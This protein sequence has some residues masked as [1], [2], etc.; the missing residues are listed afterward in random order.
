MADFR[1]FAPIAGLI[2]FFTGTRG[3]RRGTWFGSRDSSAMLSC[4]TCE[5]MADAS[6]I[7]SVITLEE[8]LSS[9]LDSMGSQHCRFRDCRKSL[10]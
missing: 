4:D 3:G 1:A 10:A 7:D 6:T 2:R 9:A 8:R 5:V